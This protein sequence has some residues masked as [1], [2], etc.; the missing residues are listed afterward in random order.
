[1]RHSATGPA[2]PRRP[3]SHG[4]SSRR[5]RPQ[6]LLPRR[7]LAPRHGPRRRLNPCCLPADDPGETRGADRGKEKRE[8]AMIG[9]DDLR[10]H[11]YTALMDQVRDLD[12]TAQ[13]SW[14]GAV[15]SAAA[16]FANA[17]GARSA[18]LMLPVVLCSAFGYYAHLRT[19]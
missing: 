7:D 1:G 11:E 8:G 19:R 18:G 17:I 12:R 10:G 13:W 6:G 14:L 3:G 2:A 16:L 15:I 9:T 4:E 5:E